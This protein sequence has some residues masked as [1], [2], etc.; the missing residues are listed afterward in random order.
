MRLM[1]NSNPPLR[2]TPLTAYMDTHMFGKYSISYSA[3]K[4]KRVVGYQFKRPRLSQENI[5]E[6][7]NGFKAAGIWPNAESI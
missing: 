3:A 5:V 6:V 7:L 1:N 4:I 2:N